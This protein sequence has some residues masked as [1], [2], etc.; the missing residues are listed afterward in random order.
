MLSEPRSSLPVR[1]VG[2]QPSIESDSLN[3]SRMVT[4]RG[5]ILF[6]GAIVRARIHLTVIEFC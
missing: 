1:A 2:C 4:A 6:P 5:R 3:L